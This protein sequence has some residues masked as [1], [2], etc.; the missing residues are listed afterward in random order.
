MHRTGTTSYTLLR[1]NGSTP[2]EAFELLKGIREETY[3]NVADWR[4][5]L[6]EADLV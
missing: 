4:I 6:A 5:A 3:K 1:W 2:E